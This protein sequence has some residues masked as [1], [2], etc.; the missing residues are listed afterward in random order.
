VLVRYLV[1]IG[2]KPR[3]VRQIVE[4]LRAEYGEWPLAA[5]PLEHDGKLVVIHEGK[6]I[7]IS[8]LM[9]GHEVIAG[10]LIA[11]LER[12]GWVTWKNPRGH[13]EVD[14]ERLSGRPTI[15]GRR[16]ATQLV[17]DIADTPAGREV[18]RAEYGLSDEEIDDAVGYEADV[19]KAVAA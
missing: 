1:D 2:L 15:R 11:A 14:P 4:D 12:G 8:A 10:T 18:L 6:D 17:A 3:E 19:R 5:A 9:P 7:Y 16:A 13:I